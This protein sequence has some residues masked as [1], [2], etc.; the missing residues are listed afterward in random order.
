MK[1]VSELL[2]WLDRQHSCWTTCVLQTAFN[3]ELCRCV[4]NRT[5]VILERKLAPSFFPIFMK[6]KTAFQTRSIWL[7]NLPTKILPKKTISFQ[8]NFLRK[9]TPEKTRFE[10]STWWHFETEKGLFLQ[11]IKS[12]KLLWKAN[13]RFK[14]F[15]TYEPLWTIFKIFKYK[16]IFYF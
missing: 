16:S 4:A 14:E 12:R 11:C 3:N 15:F 1:Q 8:A 6:N 7:K 10:K 13:L 9:E 2:T 5:I